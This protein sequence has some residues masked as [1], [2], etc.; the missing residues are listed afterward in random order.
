MLSDIV[1]AIAARK[2]GNRNISRFLP[3]SPSTW[4]VLSLGHIT[5]GTG[6]R[7]TGAMNF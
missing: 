6:E 2:C 1:V 7:I 4:P 5:L 3:I